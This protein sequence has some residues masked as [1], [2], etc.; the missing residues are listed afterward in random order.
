MQ[1]V[2][3]LSLLSLGLYE[4]TDSAFPLGTVHCINLSYLCHKKEPIPLGIG[5]FLCKKWELND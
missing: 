5:S 1:S 3:F 2:S 4:K